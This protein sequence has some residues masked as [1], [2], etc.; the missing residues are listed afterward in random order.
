MKEVF[1]SKKKTLLFS[2]EI[3]L[4]TA[5]IINVC[6]DDLQTLL[7]KL[8]YPL[9]FFILTFGYSYKHNLNWN[10][11]IVLMILYMIIGYFLFFDT[12]SGIMILE[13]LTA[14]FIA[15]LF[16]ILYKKK[17]K[18]DKK[19]KEY[20][21][22][23]KYAINFLIPLILILILEFYFKICTFKMPNI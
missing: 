15:N 20:S 17:N 11:P 7:V 4:L 22:K 9:Y 14:G 3:F 5:I 12:I 21:P 13:S 23:I 6:S 1:N 10:I 16:L 8:L 2:L 19:Y 18:I